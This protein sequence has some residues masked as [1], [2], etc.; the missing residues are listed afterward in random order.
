ML[1]G[2]SYCSYQPVTG[3]RKPRA[4]GAGRSSRA[5]AG[6]QSR[7][8][9]ATG[10]RRAAAGTGGPR[11]TDERPIGPP[12][13]R[14]LGGDQVE[15]RQAVRELFLAGKRRVREVLIATDM[16]ESD[17]ID[18]IRELA[19]AARV[20]ITEVSRRQLDMLTRSEAPQGVMA[21]AAP[22]AET[23]LDVLLKRT[24]GKPPFLLALDG[25][26]DPGNLGALLRTAEG[27][28]VTGVLLPKYRAAHITPTVAKSAAGAIEHIPMAVVSG[29]ASTLAMCRQKGLWVVGLDDE[30]EKSLF[31][32][33]D[34]AVEGIVLV[35]GA[36]GAGLSRLVS[37]RCDMLVS[38][39]MTG[40]L[41]SL[42]VSTAGA[43]ACY[44][45]V[46]ARRTK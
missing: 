24:V 13:D 32:I 27:A 41:S 15:G 10:R 16:A 14:G 19:L 8:A 42:N 26:T 5:A 22:L 3:Q 39:P 29:L 4:A 31:E 44:E 46:R 25:V 17:M 7:P 35:L 28:G 23:E 1:V 20:T 40:Q 18:D 33:G 36:E 37:E 2:R 45:V 21:K 43:L 12:K 11:R 34:L 9:A 6:R 30:A 38:I